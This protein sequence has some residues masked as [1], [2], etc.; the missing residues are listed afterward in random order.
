MPSD[1]HKE[2]LDHIESMKT[3]HTQFLV[4]KDSDI[5]GEVD[6]NVKLDGS[7]DV[8][9][10]KGGSNKPRKIEDISKNRLL[11]MLQNQL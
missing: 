7:F 5:K 6:I 3:K 2:A 1:T 8:T 11:E 9:V 4:R 10:Y